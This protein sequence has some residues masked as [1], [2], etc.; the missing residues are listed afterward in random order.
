MD[1]TRSSMNR[2]RS[3]AVVVVIA[4]VSSAHIG[5]PDVFYDGNAGPYGVHVRIAPPTV[6]P[7]IAWVFVRTADADIK[8]ILI[9][10]VYWRAGV[11]GAPAGDSLGPVAGERGLYSGKIWMMSHGAYSMYVD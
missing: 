2:I 9:R 11:Q 5:S 7:G 6:I 8:S 10:P 3:I 1:G 4:A